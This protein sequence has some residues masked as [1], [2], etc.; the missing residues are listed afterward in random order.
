MVRNHPYWALE[1]GIVTDKQ[2][3]FHIHY[4]YRLVGQSLGLPEFMAQSSLTMPSNSSFS[5][6]RLSYVCMCSGEAEET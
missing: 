3:G 1:H 6:Q 5:S 2:D 4:V